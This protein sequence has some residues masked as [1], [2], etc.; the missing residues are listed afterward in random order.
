MPKQFF[1]GDALALLK[2][3]GRDDVGQHLRE[4]ARAFARSVQ[5]KG[6]D[7]LDTPDSTRL[8]QYYLTL[9]ALSIG[10]PISI[11]DSDG[12]E[13]AAQLA[14]AYIQSNEIVLRYRTEDGAAEKSEV[15]ADPENL[16]LKNGARAWFETRFVEEMPPRWAREAAQCMR[17][18]P[19]LDALGSA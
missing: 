1:I 7:T 9:F 8:V 15:V 14:D 11:V 2:S 5:A 6:L 16:R 3:R 10:T 18:R 19:S 13:V 12:R 17:C 4:A